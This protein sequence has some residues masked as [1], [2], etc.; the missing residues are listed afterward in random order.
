MKKNYL[1][2][3]L[4]C[5]AALLCL[6]LGATANG[7]LYGTKYTPHPKIPLVVGGSGVALTL[8]P[9]TLANGRDL[10]SF[11][12]SSGTD[13]WVT[14]THYGLAGSG[15]VNSDSA[16]VTITAD[17][18]STGARTGYVV[19]N[20]QRT[21]SVQCYDTIYLLQP[22]TWCMD[23]KLAS[24][25]N[26][27]F[28][29]FMENAEGSSSSTVKLYLYA[30]T[31]ADSTKVKVYNSE[32]PSAPDSIK[33]K[34]ARV[35]QI[36]TKTGSSSSDIHGMPAYNWEYEKVTSKSLRVVAD[37]A[38][39]LSAYNA[40][41][42]T[43]GISYVIPTTGLGD[44]YFVAS[45]STFMQSAVSDAMPEEFMIIATEDT[46][47][48]TITPSGETFGSG[49]YSTNNPTG[50]RKAK[51]PFTVTLHKGQTYL[52]RSRKP[53]DNQEHFIKPGLT[54]THVKASRP[55]AVFGGHKRAGLSGEDNATCAA[56]SRDH[57]F[58]Q[59]LP[60]RSWGKR[61]AFALTNTGS[62]VYRVVAAYDNTEVAIN[63]GS[64][65]VETLKI[66]RGEYIERRIS[67]TSH[68]EYAYIEAKQPVEVVLFAE[69]YDCIDNPK[70][71]NNIG[72]PFMVAL[73]PVDRGIASATFAPV[74]LMNSGSATHY[75]TVIAETGYIGQTKLERIGDNNSVAV[76]P[77]G[78]PIEMPNTPYSYVTVKVEYSNVFNYRLSNPYGFTAYAYGY[79][80]VEA[81]GYL[82]GA[83]LGERSEENA[84][85]SLPTAYC[86]GEQ[87]ST[88]PA[89]MA[90]DSSYFWYE[91]LA[92]WSE[93]SRLGS[94][95]VNT[96]RDTTYTLFVTYKGACGYELY[97]QPVTIEVKPLPVVSLSDF[98]V[99]LDAPSSIDYG[100]LPAKTSSNGYYV[101]TDGAKAGQ[102]FIHSAASE[103]NHNVA[104]RYTERSCMAADTAVIT[105]VTLDRD[106]IIRIR[107]GDD[108][109]CHG[110]TVELFVA[111]A[112]TDRTF[113]WYYEA[114]SASSMPIAI[115]G[116]TS[117]TY[118][119][120]PGTAYYQTGKFSAYV[121]NANGCKAIVSDT[122]KIY[123]KLPNPNIQPDGSTNACAGASYKLYDA[124]FV[125]LTTSGLAYQWYKADNSPSNKIPG[126]TADE[127]TVSN[128]T[129]AGIHRFLLGVAQLIP[130]RDT[131]EGCWSY[132]S[133]DVTI[134]ALPNIPTIYT[135]DGIPAFCNGDSLVL[136]AQAI[137]SAGNTYEWWYRDAGGSISQLTGQNGEQITVKTQGRYSV[138]SVSANG[139][140]SKD[141][142]TEVEVAM[143]DIPGKPN[144][145]IVGS[146]PCHG[147]TVPIDAQG[148]L[149]M[150]GAISYQ[151]YAVGTGS[152]YTPIEQATASRYRVTE[153]GTYTARI[154]CSYAYSGGSSL[155]CSSPL[156]DPK[157]VVLWPYP[158][159]PDITGE[160]NV[161][162][163]GV[164]VS[165]TASPLGSVPV[166]SYQW[167]QNGQQMISSINSTMQATLT[168]DQASGSAGYTVVA[169]SDHGCRSQRQAVPYNVTVWNP[170]V[171]ISGASSQNECFGSS[172]VLNTTNTATGG[173]VGSSY[174]WYKN[175]NTINGATSSL[176]EVLEVGTARY[177]VR[178]IDSWGCESPFSS[179]VTATIYPSLT[180][181]IK[182]TAVCTGN[183]LMLAA[184][185]LDAVSYEWY[186]EGNGGGSSLSLGTTTTNT[187]R[188]DRAAASDEGQYRVKVVGSNSCRAEGVGNATINPLPA[189][190][191]IIPAARDICTGDSTSLLAST[192]STTTS[193]R[194]E[195]YLK[196]ENGKALLSPAVSHIYVKQ[197]GSYS[198]KVMSER[199]CWSEESAEEA[200]AAHRKPEKPIITPSAEPVAVCAS[201][202]VTLTAF[203]AGATSFQWYAVNPDATTSIILNE[204]SPTYNANID[205]FYVARAYIQ[206][207]SLSCPSDLI[208]EKKQVILHPVPSIPIIA[209]LGNPTCAGDTVILYNTQRFTIPIATYRW[210]RN[211]LPLSSTSSDTCL[212]TQVENANYTAVAV[213]DKGC[214]S[215]TSTAQMVS[216]RMPAVS[217]DNGDTSICFGGAVTLTTTANTGL[218]STYEWYKN[219]TLISGSISQLHTVRS[220]GD[221]HTG[222]AASYKC[223]VVDDGGCR[224]YLPSNTVTVRINELPPDLT[225]TSPQ[226]SCEGSDVIFTASPSGEGSYQWFREGGGGQL[227]PV[228]VETSEASYLIEDIPMSSAG[229]YV[230]R[231]TN[232]W[233]CRSEA[234]GL[235]VVYAL[236]QDPLISPYE[237]VHLCT[238][239]SVPLMAITVNPAN[240][241]RY[242]WFFDN[243][244]GSV[245]N[246]PDSVDRIYAKMAGT[247]SVLGVSEHKCESSKSGTVTVEIHRRPEVPVVSPDGS[248]SVCADYST[249]ISAY[250][251]GASFYQW[252]AVNTVTSVITSLVGD[253]SSRFEVKESGRYAVSAYIRYNNNQFSCQSPIGAPKEVELL[254]VPAAPVI[255]GEKTPSGGEKNSGCDGEI[256]TISATLMPNSPRVSSYRWYKNGVEMTFAA[257]SACAITQVEEAS[258]TVAVTSD[259]GCRS[260]LSAPKEVAIRT[261]P[262]VAIATNGVREVCHGNTITLSAITT[263]PDVGG[264]SY[265]WYENGE[266]MSGASTSPLYV[267]QG[268]SNPLV[269]KKASCYLFV[270][271]QYGC[272]SAA[273]SNT[274]EVNIR[275]LPPTPAVT[276]STVTPAGVCVGA[277][278]ILMVSPSRAGTYRW[279]KRVGR[280]LDTLDVTSD[281]IYRVLGAQPA[282]AGLYAV[283]ISNTYGC[284]SAYM[285]ETMLNVQNLPDVAIVETR[286]C[287]DWTEFNAVTPAGGLFTGWGCT[288]GKFIPAD[289]HQGRATVTYTY[290]APNGCY[291]SDTK[292][293]ELI[294]L[295]NTP[296]VTASGPTEVCE[297][298]ISVT[299][300]VVTS[301]DYSYT[302]QWYKDNAELPGEKALAYVASKEGSYAVKACSQGLC[303][304]TNTST[305]IAVSVLTL[306]EPPVIAAQNP[307]ICPGGATTLSVASQQQG[308]FQWYKG[309]ANKMD[310]ILNEI[311][312][313]Y[314]VSE[315]GQYAVDFVGANGCRS[316]FSNLLTVGEYPL[317]RQP[318]IVPSQ[319]N[320]FA[321]LDYKLLVKDPQADEEYGWYKNNL[322]VDVTGEAFPVYNLDGAD[323]GTYT[324]KVVDQ[325]GCYV[326]SEAYLLAWVD[327]PLFVPNIF[328]PNGDGINDYF[329]IL[330]LEDF[331]ENKLEILNKYGAVIF[332]QKNYHNRW[333]GEGLPND[334]YYYMLSLKR[335][336]GTSSLLSGYIHLKR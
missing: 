46:T 306:P 214:Q 8:K 250:A 200:I 219:N 42:A 218:N 220:E 21:G 257:D 169:I 316:E 243:G 62:N 239:D 182:D 277:N 175:D 54:G 224:S 258:Y 128:D 173:G 72:D 282:D 23:P 70:A 86:R 56:N 212:V 176:Y 110:D 295:P 213:S 133:Y 96:D 146:T 61:Y 279:F 290:T 1:S 118:K 18:L 253:T 188:I 136:T 95:A 321:G 57:L 143:R 104:Y 55:V 328:T 238:G 111:N 280:L 107:R 2:F 167:Y 190:P 58:E 307:A 177:Q 206:Y 209:V 112:L 7:T 317:P 186:F 68:Q 315:V 153:D 266:L 124:D 313:T 324:V 134:Y 305:P 64:G 334:V 283:E 263:P 156:G 148:V 19:V 84:S 49:D 189:A 17:P 264:G 13:S 51:D 245:S 242:K 202:P 251:T 329:Q 122:I 217:I 289:V 27:F 90:N 53:V 297:D 281:T 38:I 255:V 44:E 33:L 94:L 78:N 30:T 141:R 66:N 137:N 45:Y 35:E 325:H 178:I 130:G 323:T 129:I 154:F 14:F 166:A 83:Q 168:T 43:S 191:V 171:S 12:Y 300:Q 88:L 47:R 320:L 304:T 276:V 308:I 274:V 131:A 98:T 180:S 160:Q 331:V 197:P 262:T 5:I 249:F 28:V 259:R 192:S 139:C 147:D 222:Q 73:G 285:G 40:E 149:P 20:T 333:S 232:R 67:A 291:N 115:S 270:T 326:W 252:Y 135:S 296:I 221:P 87:N 39:S 140:R 25:G 74:E 271:D 207:G 59:L 163:G 109:I 314:T 138:R 302:Y 293:I 327:A 97:P 75:V 204:N 187:W 165:L 162:L 183:T 29:A 106:P 116:S 294:G 319:A 50:A 267:V 22:G 174:V 161:C 254:P 41:Q 37:S 6:S 99:C 185:P 85:V 203:A 144:V 229:Q 272:R 93:G 275:E 113:Q 142:S 126:A 158:S 71:A 332:S 34:K 284:R 311:A 4:G 26:E 247:Y 225:V 79:A 265:E 60:L 10:V 181:T 287:E 240:G 48:V 100:G 310:K 236:P 123:N 210:Y 261:R 157:T 233:R 227:T 132:N 292:I 301:E 63:T 11:S 16:V 102:I 312:P 196:N 32:N 105:V 230:A 103:G 246:L 215:P 322:S 288:D 120:A 170:T 155:T 92:K 234:R 184:T 15:N 195:W 145:N 198:A 269:G 286:A 335:G 194:F 193:T 199:S 31:G 101:Y 151:W 231:L 216:I 81:Y 125:G 278:A 244:R 179:V 226:P 9:D 268:S 273:S 211:G 205:G 36:F 172:I 127:Y 121:Y 76:I 52:V 159:V 152:T 298:S 303:W 223:Y 256:L 299:L 164:N 237:D 89:K 117:N 69:S 77:L 241:Q 24:V 260:P 82:L 3:K 80:N 65:S 248:I 108:T 228:T 330:G 91:S 150:G 336:N 309:D 201:S 119:V 235:A 114:L 318:E 208:S